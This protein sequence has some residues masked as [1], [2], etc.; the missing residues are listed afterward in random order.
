MNIPVQDGELIFEPHFFSEQ[1]SLHLFSTLR[2][3]LNWKEESIIIFGRQVMQPRLLA[4][5]ADE[6]KAY[7]Y[8]GKTNQPNAWS[9]ALLQI[10]QRVEEF[11]KHTFNSC[12]CNLYR[13]GSDSMGWHSDDEPE[14]GANPVIASVSLGSTRSFKLQHKKHK[15]QKLSLELNSGSLLLMAGS[16]QHYYKHSVPKTSKAVGERINLTFRYIY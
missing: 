15:Q 1:E 11:S 9:P 13:N 12:L 2:Y 6:G 10:K 5:Y 4:W 16:T 14:L 8:S 3:E 7:T